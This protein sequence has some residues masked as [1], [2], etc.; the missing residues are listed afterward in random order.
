MAASKGTP[1]KINVLGCSEAYH[2][3][4]KT[5]DDYTIYEI[6]GRR[7]DGSEIPFKLRSFEEIDTGLQELLV[8]PHTSDKHGTSYTLSNANP[9][10]GGGGVKLKHE[11]EALR[12]TVNSLVARVEALEG[13]RPNLPLPADGAI[14]ELAGPSNAFPDSEIPF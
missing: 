5:G 3:T 9:K 4:G 14:P 11:V 1:T 13:K 6:D 2:G 7:P 10:K 8:K 12:G